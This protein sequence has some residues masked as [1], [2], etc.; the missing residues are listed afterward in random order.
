MGKCVSLR[1]MPAAQDTLDV[2]V[3]NVLELWTTGARTMEN[4]R[5]AFWA[6]E[7]VCVMKGFMAQ[8]VKC[9]NLDDMAKTANQVT[10]AL[11]YLTMVILRTVVTHYKKKHV[12][13]CF[14]AYQFTMKITYVCL[15]GTICENILTNV[16]VS[17]FTHLESNVFKNLC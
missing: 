6:M 10:S 3:S 1:I 4:A 12:I 11:Y 9:V 14:R 8:H 2:T 17:F 5:M 13:L 16:D 7:S 15:L